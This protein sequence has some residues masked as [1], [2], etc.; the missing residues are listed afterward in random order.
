MSIIK[1]VRIEIEVFPDVAQSINR[2]SDNSQIS[3]GDVV[4]RMFF[5]YISLSK[6]MAV[7]GVMKD[8]AIRI[9]RLTKE[10]KVQA[11]KEI[12]NRLNSL[13]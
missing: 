11:Y 12:I 5:K 10:E 7:E 6:E 13:L 2:I 4:D 8:I 3:P 9:D 1:K